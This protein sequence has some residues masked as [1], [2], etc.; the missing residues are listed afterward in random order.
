MFPLVS[1]FHLFLKSG[2]TVFIGGVGAFFH[3]IAKDME[4][5][6]NTRM[7]PLP[8][9]AL[10][11]CGHEYTVDNLR[12]AAWLEPESADVVGRFLLASAKRNTGEPTVPSLIG[13]G[14]RMCVGCGCYAVCR[15]LCAVCCVPCAL[16]SVLPCACADV[17]CPV[18]HSRPHSD[19][20]SAGWERRTNPYFRGRDAKLRKAVLERADWLDRRRKLSY[21]ER[22][23]NGLRG[24]G[25][26]RT[27]LQAEKRRR[28]TGGKVEPPRPSAAEV[29]VS[30]VVVYEKLQARADG[31]CADTALRNL[32]W[33]RAQTA[34]KNLLCDLVPTGISPAPSH[35]LFVT[36]RKPPPACSCCSPRERGKGSNWARGL[37]L[38]L[39]C[40]LRRR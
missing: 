30:A 28:S 7:A 8:D 35:A 16:L 1:V 20:I 17:R 33:T 32:P 31:H 39:G 12:F 40:A 26:D 11:F 13:A 23:V 34:G 24:R 19:R 5:N 22:F 36:I 9:S 14:M 29:E 27:R 2:D 10:L 4:A 18:V 21:G 38:P 6:L 15:V 3:G 25:F 37:Q